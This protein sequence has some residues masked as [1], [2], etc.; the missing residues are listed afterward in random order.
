M[1]FPFFFFLL[2]SSC[3]T[4]IYSW[5]IACGCVG[6]VFFLSLS[7][8]SGK[9]INSNFLKFD[10]SHGIDVQR[11]YTDVLTEILS[12]FG[13]SSLVLFK[14]NK[15][16]L[17]Q[18][19]HKRKQQQKQ[20]L[21]KFYCFTPSRILRHLFVHFVRERT[22]MNANMYVILYC[23]TWKMERNSCCEN[24]RRKNDGTKNM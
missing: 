12:Y 13:C 19:R 23:F 5:N 21:S 11:G 15:N 3:H 7:I 17:Q 8:S 10:L 16:G 20:Q 1:L 18:M 9:Q 2:L 22:K 6:W 24:E 4:K 14:L